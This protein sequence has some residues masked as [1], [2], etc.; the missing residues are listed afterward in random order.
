MPKDPEDPIC[1]VDDDP[2]VR[3]AV[4]RLL[5]SEGWEVRSF[6]SGEK[7][8][9]YVGEHGVP[10]VILDLWMPGLNGLQVQAMLKELS[11]RSRVII[12]TARDDKS[13][14]SAAMKGGASDFFL[15]PFDDGQLLRAVQCALDI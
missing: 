11:P 14:H 4:S 6:E 7:F 8:L 1:V 10:L 15:K 5:A 12:M 2:S 3:K 13:L 9:A